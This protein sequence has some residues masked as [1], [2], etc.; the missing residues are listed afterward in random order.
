[1]N[2]FQKVTKHDFRKVAKCNS[3]KHKTL[4]SGPIAFAF[5]KYRKTSVS[6]GLAFSILYVLKRIFVSLFWCL[7]EYPLHYIVV[8]LFEIGPSQAHNGDSPVCR[9]SDSLILLNNTYYR[10]SEHLVNS[11]QIRKKAGFL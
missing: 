4:H 3:G 9:Y 7:T 6:R 10:S 1:M 8:L 11:S 2:N 5:K